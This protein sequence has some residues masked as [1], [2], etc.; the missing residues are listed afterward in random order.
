MQ[1]TRT[2]RTTDPTMTQEV[3]NKTMGEVEKGWV[4]G[5]ARPTN[6]RNARG[7]SGQPTEDVASNRGQSPTLGR[8]GEHGSHGSDVL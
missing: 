7:P 4:S 3:Y 6:S 1:S 8:L 5:R 2:G